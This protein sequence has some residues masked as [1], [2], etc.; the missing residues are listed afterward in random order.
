MAEKSDFP[1]LATIASAGHMEDEKKA[2]TAHDDGHIEGNALLVNRQD[3]IRKIPVPSRGRNMAG[4][5]AQDIERKA[6]V[7][8][9]RPWSTPSS[10]PLRVILLS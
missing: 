1:D 10:Q 4:N 5:P 9:L 8:R 2:H 6:Y 7:E 3:E